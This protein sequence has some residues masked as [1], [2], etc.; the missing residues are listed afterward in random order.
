[1]LW[2]Y[3]C[4]WI[5]RW[6]VKW[7]SVWLFNCLLLLS[8][9]AW[10]VAIVRTNGQ[11]KDHKSWI[12]ADCLLGVSQPDSSVI[13]WLPCLFSTHFCVH[14][15]C[16]LF[17]VFQGLR[18]ALAL[19]LTAADRDALLFKV[20]CGTPVSVIIHAAALQLQRNVYNKWIQSFNK[21][22]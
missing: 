20:L 4:I 2:K 14:F 11:N 13:N 12:M 6:A 9:G 15:I 3:L 7:G 22:F 8:S 18:C 1:M 10:L 21:L 19:F 17:Q 5:C 16:S